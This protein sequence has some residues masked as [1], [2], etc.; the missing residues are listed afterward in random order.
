M[1]KSVKEQIEE[2]L[3]NIEHSDSSIEEICGYVSE[4]RTLLEKLSDIEWWETVT[5]YP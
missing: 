5:E 2:K 3:S 1:R 4:V